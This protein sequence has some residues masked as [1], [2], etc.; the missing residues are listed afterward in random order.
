M[1]DKDQAI[2]LQRLKAAVSVMFAHGINRI[3]SYYGENLLCESEMREFADYVTALTDL[4]KDGKYRI[5][6]LVYYPFENLC[7]DRTPMGIR[8]GTFVG[9]D[10]LGVGKVSAELMKRQIHF[11][12]I[13]KKKLLACKV[14]DGCLITPNG[15]RV[16]HVVLPAVT[17]LD[18][19]VESL[20]LEAKNVGVK[21]I[22]GA[23]TGDKC[24]AWFTK[25]RIYD[26]CMMKTEFS[27]AE[28]DPYILTMHR[29]FSDYDMFMFVN[30]DDSDHS[31]D[32]L[33]DAMCKK[34]VFLIDPLT[35][36]RT[37]ICFDTEQGVTNLTLN[38]PALNTLIVG[39]F[40]T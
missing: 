16:Y 4:F 14:G 8:E 12:I 31:I 40:K 10:H 29:A 17:W 33:F 2:T 1:V 35:I 32:V 9:E 5:N 39:R 19:E 6:T 27:L 25:K 37:P 36:E 28:A 21:I 18:K 26:G 34:E 20:L 13:N 3:T 24:N 38:I 23:E 7:A 15:E 30:T 11:D 22:Y